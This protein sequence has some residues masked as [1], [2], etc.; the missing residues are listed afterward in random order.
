LLGP[1]K[2]LEIMVAEYD[3]RRR[4]MMKRIESLKGFSCGIPKGAFYLFP[5]ITAYYG[6]MHDGRKI[7]TSL[8]L[9]SFLLK[10]GHIAVVPG[11]AF[12]IGGRIRISY[13]NSMENL[14]KGM[15]RMEKALKFLS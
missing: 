3:R 7:A 14:E 4:Y 6:T 11:E 9:A 1:R 5:D 15:D 10:Y 12:H 2:D 8:D 13:A